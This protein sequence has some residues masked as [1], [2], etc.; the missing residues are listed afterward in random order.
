MRIIHIIFCI[1]LLAFTVVQ[2]NDPD[3]FF[4]MPVYG[5]PAMLAA[6]AAYS[7]A[8]L[9]HRAMQ[10]CIACCTLLAVIGT[11]LL[12]PREEFFWQQAIW[13]QSEVAREGVGMMIVTIALLT[14]AAGVARNGPRRTK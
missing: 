8:A 11:V 4:W 7:P 2:H 1:V 9:R 14:L 10:V 6:I 3:Y 13:W 12:W 5:V